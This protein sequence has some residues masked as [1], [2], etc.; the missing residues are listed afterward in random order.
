MPAQPMRM[1][2]LG[3]A[4]TL[5]AVKAEVMRKCLRFIAEAPDLFHSISTQHWN[6]VVAAL[7]RKTSDGPP[8][9]H[10]PIQE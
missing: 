2:S 8:Q 5:V 1:V 6:A 3:E 7:S 4:V 9:Q 10:F